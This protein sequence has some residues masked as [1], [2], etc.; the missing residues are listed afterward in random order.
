MSFLSHVHKDLRGT[1]LTRRG[2]TRA[3]DDV[4]TGLH[5]SYPRMERIVLPAP[6]RMSTTLVDALDGRRSYRGGT[7]TSKLSIENCGTL[8]GLALGNKSGS[9]RRN[10]P[11]AGALYPIETYLITSALENSAPS[12]FHYNPT[13]HSLEKLWDLPQDVAL[14]DLAKRPDDLL[15]SSLIVFTAVWER[16]SAKYGDLAYQH[17]L[18]EAGHMSEN[19]L[20][21]AT[22]L[23]LS[24]RPM[25]GFD[26]DLLVP[27]LD[28]NAEQEQPVHSIVL[29]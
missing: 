9:S 27:L 7:D 17:A 23:E 19:M 25:A 16:S 13:E 1:R 5:K 2:A 14:K 28:L 3:P 4:P 15:F 22:A 18:L 6:K 11:S 10:Y 29:S 12:I 8:F 24:A 21:T 20:L 26:D